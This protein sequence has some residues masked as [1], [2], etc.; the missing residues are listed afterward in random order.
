MCPAEAAMA[1]SRRLST[2]IAEVVL[3][4]WRVHTRSV[5]LVPAGVMRSLLALLLVSPLIAGCTP[6]MPVKTDFGTSAMVPAGA[7]PPEYADFNAA[8]SGVNAL[9]ANQICATSYRPGEAGT[10]D[11]QPGQLAT[12]RGTCAPHTPILGP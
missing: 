8:D 1:P 6:Y 2:I 11:A 10:I 7:I 9:L 3:R 4:R 12:A 5:Q